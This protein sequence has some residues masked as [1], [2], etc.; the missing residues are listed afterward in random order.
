MLRQV[1][2]PAIGKAADE[3]AE[4]AE[5]ALAD[6]LNQP[7]EAW[8]WRYY[9]EKVRQARYEID[10][11]A[12]KPYFVLDNMVAAAFET[13]GRLFGISFAERHDCPVYH[14][15]VRAYEV[16]DAAG[17]PGCEDRPE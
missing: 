10:E 3:R 8:D 1:W 5:A 4:L 12:V 6:G 14:P 17:S 16:R 15:D 11:A 13:A 2:A 7:I 9:A